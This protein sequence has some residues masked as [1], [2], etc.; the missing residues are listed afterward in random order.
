[1]AQESLA[2]RSTWTG[3]WAFIL[4]AAASAVGLGNLWRFPYLAAKYG[5]GAFLLTYIVLVFTFGISL[6]VL[7]VA[8][9]RKTGQSAVTAFKSLKSRY[10]FIGIIVSIIPFIIAPYYCIIGGW[11]LKYFVAYCSMAPS[12]LAD[13]GQ[14]FISFI[15]GS[16]ESFIYM[17]LFML[18]CFVIV[19]LGVEGGIEKANLVMMPLLI[20][21]AVGLAIYTMTLPGASAGVAYYLLPDFSKFSAEMVLGAM[22]QMFYSM[23]LAMGIIITY[24]SYMRKTDAIVSSSVRIAGFDLLVAFLAGLMMVPASFMALGSAEAVS[25]SAGPSL[26]F[27]IMPNLIDS[28]G[29]VGKLIGIVF[30]VLVLFAALT[31]AIS[32]VETC[33]SILIDAFGLTRRYALVAVYLFI[34]L[35]GVFVDLGFSKLSF[36]EPLGAGSSLLDLFDFVSNVVLMPIAAILTCVFVGWVITPQTIIDEV[37]SSGKFPFTTAWT[38]LIKYVAPVLIAIILVGYVGAQFGFIKI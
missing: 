14:F 35:C 32:L 22:G 23:S 5:G 28:M 37:K 7:E 27:I 34:F 33:G 30:F 17:A 26:M 8:I 31:S 15:T 16:S 10:A 6:M 9:G 12:A 36:I 1:M 11:V 29:T 13:E 20:L 2:E 25:G 3:K 24:G 19:A 4:A 18:A 38:F 21:F